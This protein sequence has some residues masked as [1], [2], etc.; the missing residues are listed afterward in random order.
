MPFY[1]RLGSE[2]VDAL[3]RFHAATLV[4]HLVQRVR[5]CEPLATFNVSLWLTFEG[6]C[7]GHARNSGSTGW[8]CIC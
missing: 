6:R 2:D 8:D 1:I 4:V 3:H 5:V 7:T